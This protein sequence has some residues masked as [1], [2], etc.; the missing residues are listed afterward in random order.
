[1]AQQDRGARF[2]T[3]AQRFA[4]PLGGDIDNRLGAVEYS[5]LHLLSKINRKLPSFRAR[6]E[7]RLSNR[8]DP[9]LSADRPR[10]LSH[11]LDSGGAKGRAVYG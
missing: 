10:T 11:F 6:H 3:C 8:Y 2:D 9:N 5:L 1:M 7:R 4:E